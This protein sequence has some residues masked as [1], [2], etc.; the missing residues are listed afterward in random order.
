M[1]WRDPVLN[2]QQVDTCRNSPK[3]LEQLIPDWMWIVCDDVTFCQGLKWVEMGLHL[4]LKDWNVVSVW[5]FLSGY[6][7]S[8][9]QH[10]EMAHQTV[11]L[12]Y[13]C[14]IRHLPGLRLTAISR[15]VAPLGWYLAVGCP[16]RGKRGRKT[17]K[18]PQKLRYYTEVMRT[19]VRYQSMYCRRNWTDV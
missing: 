11:V 2:L 14:Q 10:S 8:S 12:R 4:N 17:R 5:K 16:L 18:G 13:R 7:F 15:W 3:E 9:V 19:A 6:L 1:G